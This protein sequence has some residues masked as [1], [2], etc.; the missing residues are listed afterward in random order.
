M[1]EE[2]GFC[3]ICGEEFLFNELY[4]FEGDLFCEDCL[5]SNTEI[6][7]HCGQRILNSENAG[8]ESQP[9]CEDCYDSYYT[10]CE[11]YYVPSFFDLKCIN[12]A[13]I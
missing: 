3:V 10:S 11:D 5:E 13:Y 6:C 9:L 12:F 7:T 2:Y 4:E 8:S 1:K